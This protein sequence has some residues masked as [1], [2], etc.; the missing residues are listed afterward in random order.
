[1]SLFFENLVQCVNVENDYETKSHL[2]LMIISI[3]YMFPEYCSEVLYENS[4]LK[5]F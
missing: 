3:L 5:L 4:I 2:L 1:M